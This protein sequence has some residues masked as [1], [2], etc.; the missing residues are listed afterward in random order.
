MPAQS[1][2]WQECVTLDMF[3]PF[4]RCELIGMV[5]DIDKL[6]K[7]IKLLLDGEKQ[8]VKVEDIIKVVTI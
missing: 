7:R 3:D 6:G 1:M 4:E 5:I 2:E 8:W